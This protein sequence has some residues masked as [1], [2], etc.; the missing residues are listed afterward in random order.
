[1]TL[2]KRGQFLLTPSSQPEVHAPNS[3]PRSRRRMISNGR[4]TR[5]AR[6]AARISKMHPATVSRLPAR[7]PCSGAYAK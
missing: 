4:K 6:D 3:G 5:P 2:S 7:S 1:M